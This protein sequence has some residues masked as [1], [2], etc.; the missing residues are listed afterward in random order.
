MFG[1][2]SWDR[3]DKPTAMLVVHLIATMVGLVVL[4]TTAL[5]PVWRVGFALGLRS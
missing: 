1:T 4:L 3:L 2:V 5:S